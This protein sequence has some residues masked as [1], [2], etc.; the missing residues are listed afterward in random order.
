MEVEH[1][2]GPKHHLLVPSQYMGGGSRVKGIR[3]YGLAV[4]RKRGWGSRSNFFG[5]NVLL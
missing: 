3:G 1:T 5:R 2:P 4:R